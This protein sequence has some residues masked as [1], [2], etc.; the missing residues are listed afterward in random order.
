MTTEERRKLSE[1]LI[2]LAPLAVA[3]ETGKFM[4]ASGLSPVEVP[5]QMIE[6]AVGGMRDLK[7]MIYGENKETFG[8]RA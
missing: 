7:V 2:K 6:C 4:G 8:D 3:H 1:I 5:M